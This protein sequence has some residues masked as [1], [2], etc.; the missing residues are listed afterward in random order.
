MQGDEIKSYFLQGDKVRD[1][2]PLEQFDPEDEELADKAVKY[3][4]KETRRLKKAQGTGD[5][6][7]NITGEVNHNLK[8]NCDAYVKLFEKKREPDENA[9]EWDDLCNTLKK[10]TLKVM[11]THVRGQL[12]NRC[13]RDSLRRLKIFGHFLCTKMMNNILDF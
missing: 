13:L 12:S 11:Q 3:I 6:K 5:T 10:E 2:K 9:K 7:N 8:A 1:T 4:N